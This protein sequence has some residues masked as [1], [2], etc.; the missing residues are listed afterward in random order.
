MTNSLSEKLVI[1][2]S[3]S[4]VFDLAEADQV[5]RT[6]GEDAF[7]IYQRSKLTQPA[8]P[9]VAFNL[10]SKLLR[11]NGAGEQRVEIVFVS[12]NDPFSGLRSFESA[13]AHNLAITRGIFTGG[14]NPFPYVKP[15]N[16][17]LFISTEEQVVRMS[18][19]A[20]VPAAQV[21]QSA[22]AISSAHPG[23]LRIAFDGDGVLFDDGSEEIFQRYGIEVFQANEAREAFTPLNP[24]PLLPFV[25][26]LQKVQASAELETRI[27]LVTARNAPAHERAIRTLDAWGIKVHEAFFLGGL[28]KTPFIAAFAPDIF[29]DDQRKH[30]QPAA[31]VASVAHVPYGITNHRE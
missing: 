10:V 11:L 13:K 17:V 24:G 5:Y 23:Q 3:T 22:P 18:L 31:S 15:L 4:A 25:K 16:P 20:G 9:G 8:R 27:A 26:A 14:T 7:M 6:A 2:A 29:F 19:D 12:R 1:A 21:G 30:T 28:P